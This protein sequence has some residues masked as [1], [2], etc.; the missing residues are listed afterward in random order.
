MKQKGNS[1]EGKRK[2]WDL[3]EEYYRLQA[4]DL[5][6]WE[7]RRVKRLKGEVDGIVK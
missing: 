3:N 2:P 6:D 5:D 4:K 1:G 7:Q